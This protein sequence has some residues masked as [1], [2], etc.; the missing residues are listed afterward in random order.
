LLAASDTDGERTRES[1]ATIDGDNA[2]FECI[3]KLR[4]DISELRLENARMAAKLAEA[5]SKVSE[6]SFVSERLR[7]EARG[8]AGE[9]GERGRD[10]A[11]GRRGEPGL[12]GERGEPGKAAPTIAGWSVDTDNFTAVAILSDGQTSGLLRLRPLF[13]AFADAL[14][15]ADD[16]ADADADRAQ[17]AELEL[18][19]TR[20]RAGLP[21]R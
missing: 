17:R 9:R 1:V 14:N 13:E 19:V 3:K 11:D 15:D 18:Q 7:V 2:L 20:M 12:R 8:P 10:G 4:A 6:L 16:V 21:A 5:T